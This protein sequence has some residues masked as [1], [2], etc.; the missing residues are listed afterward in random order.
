MLE[1]IADV[2]TFEG[3]SV[4]RYVKGDIVWVTNSEN[5]Q[6]R[7]ETIAIARKG[8]NAASAQYWTIADIAANF[9]I[10]N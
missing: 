4:R 1:C 10:A 2:I 9:R 6:K 8:K 5:S 7:L 3:R